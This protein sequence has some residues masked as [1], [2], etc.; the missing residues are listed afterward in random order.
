[1]KNVSR[2][3]LLIAGIVSFVCALVF[4]IMGIV[5]L[6]LTTPEAK[7]IIIEGLQNGSI[8]TS[9]VGQSVEEQAATIQIILGA[10]GA[11]FMVWAV[12]A[13]INGVISLV[14]RA[15][16]TKGWMII[17]IVCGVVSGLII[18]LVGGILGVIANNQ[19]N[20]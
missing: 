16:G 20:E 11:V 14:G 6:A 5:Y 13:L 18:N 4:L 7:Q 12:L 1:M 3:L 17:N 2:I 10:L 9:V 19:Q 15:K 8:N